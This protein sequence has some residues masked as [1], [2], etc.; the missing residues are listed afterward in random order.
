MTDMAAKL[1]DAIS[2]GTSGHIGRPIDVAH[3]ARMSLGDR[4]LER[5]VLR[6]FDIQMAMLSDRV[7]NAPPAIAGAAAHTIKGSARGIGAWR[8]AQ[9]AEQVELSIAS[10][11]GFRS[12]VAD[13]SHS[14]DEARAAVAQLLRAN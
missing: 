13:L 11:D 10:A 14:I 12:A 2:S 8:V 7:R 5:E 4:K 9:T 6:L 1:P 3:L